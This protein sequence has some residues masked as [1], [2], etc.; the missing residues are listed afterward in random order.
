MAKVR[1]SAKEELEIV[2]KKF[3]EIQEL[4]KTTKEDYIKQQA[5]EGAK[6]EEEIEHEEL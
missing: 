2:I 4:V 6:K 5:E 1:D 3:N